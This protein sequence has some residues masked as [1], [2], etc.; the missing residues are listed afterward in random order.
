VFVLFRVF[1][2]FE[3]GFGVLRF[4][5]FCVLDSL[6]LRCVSFVNCSLIGV[7]LILVLCLCSFVRCWFCVYF[8]WF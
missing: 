3:F 7:V 2:V 4:P 6:L 5:G 1:G 8:V